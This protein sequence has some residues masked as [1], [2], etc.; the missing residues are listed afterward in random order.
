VDDDD[1]GNFELEGLS[2]DELRQVMPPPPPPWWGRMERYFPLVLVALIS[3]NLNDALDYSAPDVKWLWH[4]GAAFALGLFL[5]L[6]IASRIR[7]DR[8]ARIQWILV[9][10]T[11]GMVGRHHATVTIRPGGHPEVPGEVIVELPP[12][13]GRSL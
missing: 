9:A 10:R 13:E 8:V 2:P 7:S 1:V 12:E 4:V 11:F 6:R 5:G 3:W